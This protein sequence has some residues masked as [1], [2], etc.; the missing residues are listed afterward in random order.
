[1]RFKQFLTALSLSVSACV[2]TSCGLL[3]KKEPVKNVLSQG[4][5]CY[6]QLGDRV[7]RYLK[8]AIDEKEWQSTFECVD[9]QVQY[10]R[11]Y[12]RGEV[13]DGFNSKDIAELVRRFLITNRR[14][15]DDFISAL[16]DLKASL[17]GGSNQKITYA[18][19]DEFLRFSA[20][21]KKQTTALL[22]ALRIR[23]ERASVEGLMDL[24]SAMERFGV[25]LAS[26][27]EGLTGSID[28][29]SSSILPFIREL[30]AIH[31]GDES[32]VDEYGE[33]ARH[34]KV[35]LAGGSPEQVE[36]QAWPILIRAG[37]DLGGLFLAYT[38]GDRFSENDP[39][40]KDRLTRQLI[41]RFGF[42]ANRVIARHGEGVSLD[43]VD[44]LIDTF[45]GEGL[46]LLKRKALKH[47]IRA[48][49]YRAL[50]SGKENRFTE[51]ALRNLLSLADRGFQ[52]QYHLKKIYHELPVSPQL[53]E[54]ES[55]A[56]RYLEGVA[57]SSDRLSV[58]KL[59]STAK[60]FEGL[61]PEGNSEMLFN[62]S[63]RE[64]RT[65][66]HMI[67]MS[68]F[69][70]A[71]EYLFS[72]Y[73][74]GPEISRTDSRKMATISDLA[75]LSTDFME[76]LREWKMAHPTLTAEQMAKK[77]FREG[78]LFM[79][80]ANGD[81][82]FDHSE[83][84]YY[85]AFLFSS[86]SFST[87][88]FD[89]IAEDHPNWRGCPIVGVDQLGQPA[90]EAE[91]FRRVY[92][93]N[94]TVF[95]SNFPALQVAYAGMSDAQ[96]ASLVMSMEVAGRR[97]GYSENPIG[98]FD[99]D[100]FAALPHYVENMFAR[101][102]H[103]A[104]QLLDKREI[105]DLAYP[106]FKSTLAQE[107]ETRSDFILKGV[108]TYIVHYGKVPSGANLM[109][110]NLVQRPLTKVVADRSAVYKVVELLSSP[111]D[112]KKKDIDAASN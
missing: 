102:D 71:I 64:T 4:S 107:V 83:A 2:L 106:I 32:V 85:L 30:I 51:R 94:P 66:N 78:N 5:G 84:T 12:V 99:I 92:F 14:V 82:F 79:P 10:F 50:K 44:P 76:I 48:A 105:L 28:V 9:E 42:Y 33:F 91:C 69:R 93:G 61:F 49:V 97:G 77:R 63:I 86:G 109:V 111:L 55:A 31:G 20:E 21:L 16:F 89:A 75:L 26:Y 22:P 74:T 39:E 23:N 40:E 7:Q 24:S 88:I 25:G 90:F 52:L 60:G 17:F 103:D 98:P 80:G 41:D 46:N 15:S 3:G 38:E 81:D 110:W 18:E 67:R 101:F 87:R 56:R 100:S 6:D 58:E 53:I 11:K 72:V 62:T 19:V 47:D 35:I 65:R 57:D 70:E 104:D 8:G 96:K 34:L 1:M 29:P 54:F 37:A 13:P 45:P 73:A 68:W 95:W 112:L 108:L 43:L 36:R 59:I 27:F